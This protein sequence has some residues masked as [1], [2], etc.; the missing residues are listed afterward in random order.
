MDESELTDKEKN[1]IKFQA[2]LEE[3][4]VKFDKYFGD[5]GY[6]CFMFNKLNHS[7]QSVFIANVEDKSVIEV[8]QPYANMPRVAEA[9]AKKKFRKD[10]RRVK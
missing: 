5:L 4:K 3:T 6:C 9:K 1:D 8:L 2:F 10:M 7:G